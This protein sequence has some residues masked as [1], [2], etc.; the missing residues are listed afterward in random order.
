MRKRA[1][2][3]LILAVITLATLVLASS[4]RATLATSLEQAKDLSQQKDLPILMKIGAGWSEESNDFD[5]MAETD[6]ALIAALEKNVILCTLDAK[7]GEGAGIARSYSVLNYPTFILTNSEGETIDRWYGYGC[8][9]CFVKR[10]MASVADP[11]TLNERLKRFQKK[12]SEEDAMKIG[13]LRHAEGMFAEAVAYFR[14]AQ[15]LNPASDMNYDSMIFN[16]M[17]YGNFYE[18]FSADQVRDQP[19]VVLASARRTEADLIKVAYSMHK[20]ARRADDLSL[21]LPYLKK[22]VEGTAASEDEKIKTKRAGLMP[23]YT[24]YINKDVD[25]AIAYKKASLPEGWRKNS[26]EL[27]NFAWWCFENKVNLEEA[28]KFARRGIELAKPGTEKA[29]VLDTLAEICDVSGR[30]EDAVEYIRMAVA[31]DPGN[32]EPARF[33]LEF[34]SQ[35]MAY[36][37]RAQLL[38]RTPAQEKS[39]ADCRV[40]GG[41]GDHRRTEAR[42]RHQSH[43]SGERDHKLA[44][45]VSRDPY[46][47]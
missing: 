28:E 5:R 4:G 3:H 15:Q 18:L 23:E 16:S 10:L 33:S 44:G 37:H 47:P 26:K 2:T 19:D 6:K 21:F 17:A 1:M 27:N 22:G 38:A 40:A 25:G 45:G 13:E 24:L 7:Q 42:E 12:P 35:D 36:R 31:E 46:T 11:V 20:V 29:N 8:H 41:H 32:S 9:E 14:R 39:L 34:Y 43:R 30:C